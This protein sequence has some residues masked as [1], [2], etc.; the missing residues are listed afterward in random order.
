[1]SIKN[2]PLIKA[3]K[4]KYGAIPF[5]EIKLEHYMLIITPIFTAILM[6]IV[7]L[8]I[9]LRI[10]NMNNSSAP[11]ISTAKIFMRIFQNKK[12]NKLRIKKYKS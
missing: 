3:S 6:G 5:D 8:S 10:Y 4:Y 1:M 7:F 12:K 11:Y 9:I 2:N